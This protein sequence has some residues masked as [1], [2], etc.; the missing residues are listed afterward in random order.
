[1]K[2]C[3]FS[4]GNAYTYLAALEAVLPDDELHGADGDIQEWWIDFCFLFFIR[5]QLVGVD[6]F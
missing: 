6:P 5:G 3:V 1:M 4:S 2:L